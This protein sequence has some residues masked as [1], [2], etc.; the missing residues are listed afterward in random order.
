MQRQLHV[1]TT[2]HMPHVHAHTCDLHVNVH[3][4]CVLHVY[5]LRYCNTDLYSQQPLCI[6]ASRWELSEHGNQTLTRAPGHTMALIGRLGE[7][8]NT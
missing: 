3:V 6:L 7:T 2:C 5:F 1:Q 8:G 4:T